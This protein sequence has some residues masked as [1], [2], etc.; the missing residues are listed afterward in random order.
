[1]TVL[2][3]VRKSGNIVL[4]SDRSVDVVDVI[5][6][7]DGFTDVAKAT[8]VKVSR[9]MPDGT[10]KTWDDIDV[11]AFLRGRANRKDALVIQPGDIVNVP[12]RM[13]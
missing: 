12:M 3:Q 10:R 11:D 5:L 4:P 13:F 9:V 2:G 8:A 7:A 1:V 6:L